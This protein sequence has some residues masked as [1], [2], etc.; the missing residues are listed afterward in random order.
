MMLVLKGQPIP[1]ECGTY[2]SAQ[3]MAEANSLLYGFKPGGYFEIDDVELGFNWQ[4]ADLQSGSTNQSID[5]GTISVTRTIDRASAVIMQC[6]FNCITLDSATIIKRRAAGK[7]GLST[8]IMESGAT[9][10]RLDFTGV[11]ITAVDWS[12]QQVVT[13]KCTFVARQVQVQ[14]RPQEASGKL[15]AKSGAKWAMFT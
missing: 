1:A 15:G 3:S 5:M 13:E 2:F 4:Q 11:L 6:C 14:Y 8:Q 12:D 10:L 9:Y 7:A